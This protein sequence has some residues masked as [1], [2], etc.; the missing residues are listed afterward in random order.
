VPPSREQLEELSE[1]SDGKLVLGA[2]SLPWNY[3]R[4]AWVCGWKERVL[5]PAAA[6]QFST[7]CTR[8]VSSDPSQSMMCLWT[9]S[10]VITTLSDFADQTYSKIES[11]VFSRRR[12]IARRA[13]VAL[14]HGATE[15]FRS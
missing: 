13:D 10:C 11:V 5:D 8:I 15:L 1:E 7:S 14:I 6:S 9:S 4:E 3:T 12:N 2:Q